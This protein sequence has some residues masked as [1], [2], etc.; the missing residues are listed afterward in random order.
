M[1]VASIFPRPR[2][3]LNAALAGAVAAL[4]LSACV[5]EPSVQT[6]MPA[7]PFEAEPFSVSHDVRFA[8]Q[9]VSLRAGESVELAGFVD[10]FGVQRGDTVVVS[11]AGLLSAERRELIAH[12]L[13]AYGYSDIRFDSGGPIGDTVRVTL[14]RTS[15]LPTACTREGVTGSP[16]DVMLL[17][18]RCANDM[19]LARMVVDQ[20]DLVEGRSLGPARAAPV[21]GAV[22][23]YRAGQVR[24]LEV[25]RASEQ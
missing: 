6:T 9:T 24:E 11:G 4:A 21:V 22:S 8:P 1:A 7:V 14:Q 12:E 2:R 13:A 5:A 15:Y 16:S 10:S 20:Q 25:E 3:R 17:P 23:R 19:N 18:A